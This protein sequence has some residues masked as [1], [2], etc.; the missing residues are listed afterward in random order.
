[1]EIKKI[2]TISKKAGKAI[3]EIYTRNFSVEYKESIT[4]KEGTSPLTEADN[5]SHEIIEKELKGITPEIPILSE[6]SKEIPYE[7]RKNWKRFWLI[8]PLDGTKEFIKKNGEFTINIALIEDGKPILGVVY[9][10]VEDVV[11]YGDINGSFR[12]IKDNEPEKLPIKN[13]HEKL[14]VVASR[15]H[16]TDETKEYIEK[17]GK[18]YELISKGSS[19]KICAV[20][21]GTA[22]IYPRLGP[23]MEWDTAAAHA[24]IKFAGKHIYQYKTEKELIYNKEN[25]LNPYFIV[26]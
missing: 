13:N 20:A 18:D 3:L 8:D 11:Y 26:Q 9:V 5:K 23:T 7:K 6:E 21:E 22:D 17:I 2:I 16:F 25:L 4:F 19:L 10:P 15:S 1:M 14:I 24:V 12:Q